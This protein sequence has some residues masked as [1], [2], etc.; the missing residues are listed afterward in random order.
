MSE[1]DLV[2]LNKNVQK[3]ILLKRVSLLMTPFAYDLI[4]NETIL[5]CL[6]LLVYKS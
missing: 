4:S 3:S 5:V 2:L 6:S 1:L